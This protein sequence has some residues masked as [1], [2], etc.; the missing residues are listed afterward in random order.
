MVLEFPHTG[1]R[2]NLHRVSAVG[3]TAPDRN[4]FDNF[5]FIYYKNNDAICSIIGHIHN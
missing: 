4:K 1:G 5:N 2:Q 3:R